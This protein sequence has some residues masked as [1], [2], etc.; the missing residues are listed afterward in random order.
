MADNVATLM[1][2]KYP[3]EQF[4]SLAAKIRRL[5]L[6]SGISKNQLYRI[7]DKSQGTSVDNLEW[8]AEVLS[9]RPNDLVTPY[10]ARGADVTALP[11]KRRKT[12]TRT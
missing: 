9:V 3:D 1:D 7:L 4:K 10:F 5:E 2:R 8:L 11:T 12:P 6:E